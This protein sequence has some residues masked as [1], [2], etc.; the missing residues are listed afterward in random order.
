MPIATR[1]SLR[2]GSFGRSVLFA[3][4]V[5]ALFG[6]LRGSVAS[7]PQPDTRR[8]RRDVG[9]GVRLPEQRVHRPLHA[10]RHPWIRGGQGN[11]SGGGRLVLPRR[12]EEDATGDQ[13]GEESARPGR[14]CCRL[15]AEARRSESAEEEKEK[16]EVQPEES[17]EKTEE[18]KTEEDKTEEDKT[19][20]D[21]AEEDK[22]EED[23]AEEDKEE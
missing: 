7:G 20:E 5:S 18:D 8:I 15:S 11:R 13:P 14:R 2:L 23:K 16:D 17:E 4:R 19:E 12:R 9:D 3:S 22:I 21:K 6:S 1:S 10:L